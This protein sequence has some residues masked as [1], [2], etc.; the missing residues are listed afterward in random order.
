[1]KM[2]NFNYVAKDFIKSYTVIH[3]NVRLCLRAPHVRRVHIEWHIADDILRWIFLQRKFSISI[4]ISLKAV[5]GPLVKS[6]H[7][8]R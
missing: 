7:R 4:Q 2:T 6:R 1:M 8:F 5:N 3:T